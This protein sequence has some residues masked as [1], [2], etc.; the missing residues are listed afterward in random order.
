[1]ACG[2]SVDASLS[3]LSLTGNEVTDE[4]VK[5]LDEVLKVSQCTLHKLTLQ[6]YSIT[7]TGCQSLASA[8]IPN[9]SLTHLCLSKNN[10]GNEGKLMLNHGNLDTAGFGFLTFMLL[11]NAWRMHLSLSTNPLEDSGVKLLCKDLELV[12]CHLTATYYVIARSRY[13]RS[14]DLVDNAMGDVGIT[15]LCEGLK[16]RRSVL[17]RLGLRLCGLTS[18]CCE[19]LSFALSCNHNLASLNLVQNN[20]S[21]TGMR[22]L[23]SSFVCPMSNLHIIGLWK[24]QYPVQIRKLL[25]EVQLL[26][27]RMVIDGSWYFFH[28]NDQYW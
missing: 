16:Q 3:S 21:P 1:M 18:G 7:A 8:L 20:F 14:L 28:E 23:C 26:K 13:L 4:E 5:A 17:R 6:N 15:A 19:E 22:K 27:L 11:G 25:E 10:L 9:H 2:F 24:W 12:I